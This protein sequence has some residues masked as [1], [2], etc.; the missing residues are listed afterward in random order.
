[1]MECWNSGH[2]TRKSVISGS[3]ELALWSRLATTPRGKIENH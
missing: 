3:G 2:K 1:M